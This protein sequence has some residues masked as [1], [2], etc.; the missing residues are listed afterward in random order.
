MLHHDWA[1]HAIRVMLK[2][3]SENGNLVVAPQSLRLVVVLIRRS[4]LCSGFWQESCLSRVKFFH[5]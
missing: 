1:V 4:G 2:L 3:K 5:I